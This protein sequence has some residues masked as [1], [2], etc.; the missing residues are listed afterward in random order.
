MK[1]SFLMLATVTTVGLGTFFGGASLQTEA[2]SVSNLQGQQS[3]IQSQRS[4]LQSNINESNNKITDLQ[5]QQANV[6]EEM[7]RLDFAISD[8]SNQINEKNKKVDSTKAEIA[9]LQ[10]DIVVIKERIEKRNVLLK[11]RVRSYQENGTV[12]NYLDVL[13]GAKSFSDFIDRASAVA[14]FMEADQAIIKEHEADKQELETKESLVQKDL[15]NLQSMLAELKKMNQQL[16]T[17]MDQKNQ[18]LAGLEQQEEEAHAEMIDMQEQEQILAAQEAAIQ[19]AIKLA[20]EQAAAAAAANKGGNDS[21]GAG[22]GSAP[23]VSGG[24]FTKP[25]SGVFTSGYGARWGTFHY[26]VDIANSG[27]NV[28]IVAAADGVVYVSHYSSSYGN[29]IYIMHNINGQMYTTV[30]AHM[31]ARMVSEGAT[32]KKGQRIGT[33]GNTGDSKGQH[34]HF[35]LYR[36]KWAYHS[37]INPVGI[38]PL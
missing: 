26:G 13:M 25:A 14:T 7:K 21:S 35:E 22:S 11:E 17:Q 3:K 8:T 5:N 15:S 2:E 10:Q 31:S 30:Y 36:G 32:V 20:K 27:T 18:L 33:M 19:K 4:D 28:P 16:N 9:K 1:K 29:V 12:I 37:A 6:K 24:S 38:V 23:P 34:L